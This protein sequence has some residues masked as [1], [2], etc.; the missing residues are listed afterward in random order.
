MP[1]VEL[2]AAT[3][4]IDLLKIEKLMQ[5]Y[6]YDVSEWLPLSFGDDGN[7]FIRPKA[8]YWANAGTHAFFI[9]VDGEV[10]GFATVDTEVVDAD[11]SFS[12]GYFFVSRRFMGTGTGTLAAC[13]AFPLPE[14][15]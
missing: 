12:I 6:L 7:F 10:A 14:V 5:F 15:G 4:E 8:D 1:N 2:V 11:T 3:R 9:S 13:G